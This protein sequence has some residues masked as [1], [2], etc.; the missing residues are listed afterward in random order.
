MKI[1]INGKTIDTENILS[2]GPVIEREFDTK[3]YFTFEINY[4]KSCGYD[5]DSPMFKTNIYRGTFC[6]SYI[7]DGTE[8]SKE[9]WFK[10]ND[11][12]KTLPQY[13]ETLERAKKMRNEIETLWDMN[14]KV[15]PIRDFN[16]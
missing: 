15:F 16:S 14:I 2:I 6:T 9:W 5:Y 3:I 10:S 4:K 7:P 11:F 8:K 13:I 1:R 12:I